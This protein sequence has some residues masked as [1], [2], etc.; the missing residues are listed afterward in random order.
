AS[1]PRP[2]ASRSSNALTPPLRSTR[3]WSIA[4]STSRNSSCLDLETSAIGCTGPSDEAGRARYVHDQQPA[5][6]G[7]AASRALADIVD[8][9]CPEQDSDSWLSGRRNDGTSGVRRGGVSP[10][11]G[12]AADTRHRPH[13]ERRP[14]LFARPR[15]DAAVHAR[16]EKR[17]DYGCAVE[18]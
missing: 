12:R 2:K 16:G 14:R 6:T 8:R 1:W 13:A 15:R 4:R 5:H 9:D 18:G 10:P 17:G 7:A 3:L 11:D